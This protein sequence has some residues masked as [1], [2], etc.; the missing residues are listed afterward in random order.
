MQSIPRDPDRN[1]EP[2]SVA[3]AR[4]QTRLAVTS[5]PALARL[6]DAQLISSDVRA[7]ARFDGVRLIAEGSVDARPTRA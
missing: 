4:L 2:H 1:A 3:V 5:E 7:H 6:L